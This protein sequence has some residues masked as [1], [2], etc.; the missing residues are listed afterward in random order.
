MKK[1][2][3]GST[4][5]PLELPA[6]SQW[7]NAQVDDGEFTAESL[8]EVANHQE[9]SAQMDEGSRAV[10]RVRRM[11]TKKHDAEHDRATAPQV[12][13]AYTGA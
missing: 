9:E 4:L 1:A 10:P 3:T 13:A 5:K 8:A 6:K 11:K 2:C 12:P 7:R